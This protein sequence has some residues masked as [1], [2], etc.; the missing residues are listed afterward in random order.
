MATMCPYLQEALMLFCRAYP[1]RKMVPMDRIGASSACMQ[2]DFQG[3]PLFREAVS[4]GAVCEGC[5]SPLPA[6]DA[7]GKEKPQ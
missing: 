5:G 3:C 6:P 4:R 1:V 7:D 2:G